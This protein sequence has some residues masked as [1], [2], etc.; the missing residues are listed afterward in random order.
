[1]TA[2]RDQEKRLE[3]RR[4]REHIHKAGRVVLDVSLWVRQVCQTPRH[5][6]PTATWRPDAPSA[7]A[8][9]GSDPDSAAATA[10]ASSSAAPGVVDDACAEFDRRVPTA[11]LSATASPRGARSVT[12]PRTPRST[13]ASVGPSRTPRHA[14]V[15]AAA[16]AAAAPAVGSSGAPFIGI[17]VCIDRWSGIEG[18][19]VVKVSAGSPAA[20]GGL[21][22]G[23]YLRRVNGATIVDRRGLKDAL[24]SAQPGLGLDVEAYRPSASMVRL[25]I[26][27][28][29]RAAAGVG[30]V[31]AAGGGIRRQKGS[32]ADAHSACC[33]PR[34]R[35]GAAYPRAAAAQAQS[36][37]SSVLRRRS[38]SLGT[39]R[40]AA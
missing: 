30:S 6:D 24:G 20:E 26:Q 32:A 10:T 17:E 16:A 27:P 13:A 36:Q 34:G 37:Q 21:R 29:C 33:T 15:A 4:L 35:H 18:L 3:A 9:A 5:E 22:T 28:A 38:A 23:D 25:F 1:M 14:A 39:R 19:K 8:A 11:V 2:A 12:A 40:R 31:A 7:A